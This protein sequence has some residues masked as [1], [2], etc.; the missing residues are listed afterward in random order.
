MK[1]F[2][3]L[4][5]IIIFTSSKI[6]TNIYSSNQLCSL[7]TYDNRS[8]TKECKDGPKKETR[9]LNYRT[10]D[11]YISSNSYKHNGLHFYSSL[12]VDTDYHNF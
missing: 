10:F 9:M 11:E 6:I 5:F 12:Y 2:I 4:T 8:I 7:L 1:Y 3:L